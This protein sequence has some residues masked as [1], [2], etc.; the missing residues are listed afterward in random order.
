MH[1]MAD[2]P[3]FDEG[4]DRE[5]LFRA[6]RRHS[7]MVR[8]FRGAIP[9]SLLAVLAII[10]AAAYFQPLKNLSKLGIDPARVVVSGSK[11]NMEAPH[12]AGFTRDGRPYDLTARAAAQ[13]L[14]KP[15]VLE[16]K[17]VRA[18]VEMQDKTTVEVSA[19]AG[20]YD[21]KGDTMLLR[22]DVVVTSSSGYSVRLNEAKVDVKTNRIISDQPVEVMLSN[23]TVKAN[24]LEVSDNG[25][26]MHFEGDVD[27]NQV[28]PAA[29]STPGS[30]QAAG[31]KVGQ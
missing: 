3:F 28:P 23:G 21:T 6:A 30:G 7:R 17:D 15:G 25:T 8:F 19:A 18:R 22:T 20:T 9:V 31:V 11:I 26:T 5:I 4:N 10:A 27:V 13:D 12:L 14:A 29:A 1:D 24:R 16:L 2:A